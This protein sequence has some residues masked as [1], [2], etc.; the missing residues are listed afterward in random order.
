MQRITDGAADHIELVAGPVE[1]A[2][3][4]HQVLWQVHGEPP[5]GD[6]LNEALMDEFTDELLGHFVTIVPRVGQQFHSGWILG[7]LSM[8]RWWRKHLGE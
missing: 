7:R 6:L 3:K 2:S 1:E 5:A 8:A 4:G